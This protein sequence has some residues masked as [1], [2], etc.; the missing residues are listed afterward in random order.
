MHSYPIYFR[1]Y[2]TEKIIRPTSMVTRN[3]LTEGWLRNTGRSDNNPHGFL[4]ER[5]EIIDNHDLKV[6]TR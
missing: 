3:L 5:W 4:I 2:A 6:E 1:C